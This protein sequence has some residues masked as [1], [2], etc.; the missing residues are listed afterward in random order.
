MATLDSQEISPFTIGEVNQLFDDLAME[1]YYG[2]NF[3]LVMMQAS[4]R[5]MSALR[6]LVDEAKAHRNPNIRECHCLSLM[7]E[8]FNGA[9]GCAF[10]GDWT[11]RDVVTNS[12]E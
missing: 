9:E 4:D 3:K 5:T 6:I 2:F 10:N 12:S 11:A 1:M 8:H 7:K